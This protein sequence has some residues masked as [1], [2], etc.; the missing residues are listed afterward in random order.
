N[1][2]NPGSVF[3]EVLESHEFRSSDMIFGRFA[4]DLQPIADMSDNTN[5]LDKTGYGKAGRLA[6]YV[7]EQSAAIG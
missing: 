5:L 7:V 6:Q 4:H 1:L 3:R 2:M